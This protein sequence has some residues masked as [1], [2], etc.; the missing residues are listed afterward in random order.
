MKKRNDGHNGGSKKTRKKRH[1]PLF[2]GEKSLKAA[3]RENKARIKSLRTVGSNRANALADKLEN[4]HSKNRCGSP[5]C[6]ECNWFTCR[7]HVRQMRRLFKD[8]VE[9][10]HVTIVPIGG[11]FKPRALRQVSTKLLKDK[12]GN[13]RKKM[14]RAGLTDALVIGGIEATYKFKKKKVCL[15]WHLIFG[16]CSGKDVEKLRH[17]YLQD[18]QMRVD[19]IKPGDENKV[20]SYGLK[21]VTY[22]IDPV[23]RKPKRPKPSVHAKLMYFLDRHRFQDLMILKGFRFYGKKIRVIDKTAIRHKPRGKKTSW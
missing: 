9:Q 15:H 1:K 17:Y 5:A 7:R 2:K 20:Y 23:T 10:F 4:C 11:Y 18:R 14:E 22:G 16:N 3:K 12:K 6:A 13:L 19:P 8:Y 21:N